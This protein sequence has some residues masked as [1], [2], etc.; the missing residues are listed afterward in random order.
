MAN[1]LKKALS[2]KPS[3]LRLTVSILIYAAMITLILIFFTGN[4]EFIYETF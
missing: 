2:T 1:K 3:A 4:T